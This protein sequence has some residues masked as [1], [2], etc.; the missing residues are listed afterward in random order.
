MKNKKLAFNPFLPSWEYIPDGEPHI[1]YH[2][3]TN[4][5][6]FA[7]QACAEPIT[8]APDGSI[9]QSELTSCGLNGGPL[10]GK[11]RYPTYIAC[12]LFTNKE[13][14]Y[15]GGV[16]APELWLSSEFPKITQDGGDGD[17]NE[18]DVN[19]PDG[20]YPLYFTYRGPGQIH[21]KYFEL[22]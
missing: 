9:K 16:F 7:R 3:H 18:F 20:V 10:P 4:G 11:G 22:I 6:C 2:R 13:K 19:I 12:N 5:T 21:F 8:I 17:E 14:A 1:F 15:T